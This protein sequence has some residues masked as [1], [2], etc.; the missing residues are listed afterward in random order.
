MR[1]AALAALLCCAL[2]PAQTRDPYAAPRRALIAELQAEARGDAGSLTR[3]DSDVLVVM[4]RVPRHLYVPK[5]E[6]AHAYENRPLAIGHGQTISQP[7]IVALMTTLVQPR[8]GQ[9]ILEIGT[10]S[11]YQAAVLAE[12]GAS[13]HSIEIIEPLAA[14]AAQRLRGYRNVVTRTGDGYYGWKDAAPFDSII[15]TA[16]ASSIPPP[17]LAQLKPG[18][19]LVIPVGSSFFTQTL[20]LVQKDAQGRVRTRQILPVR[21]VPLTGGH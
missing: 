9:R 21:F 19:R 12:S 17:L 7:Y 13:V 1:Y 3:I 20:L 8:A 11:G 4:G 16:A 2:A 10:G 6:L 18:G 14:Q 5:D 15:V